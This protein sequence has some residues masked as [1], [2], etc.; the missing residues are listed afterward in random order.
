MFA[1]QDAFCIIHITIV[2]I[3]QIIVQILKKLQFRTQ[4][5]PSLLVSKYYISFN[6]PL[7]E[8][9]GISVFFARSNIYSLP[10]YNTNYFYSVLK[11]RQCK[12]KSLTI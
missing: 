5:K 9:F 1:L 7:P 3:V 10:I 12:L 4:F 6:L 2:T 11:N 8:F